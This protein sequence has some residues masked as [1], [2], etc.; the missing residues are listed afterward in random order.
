MNRSSTVCRSTRSARQSNT[1]VATAT[2]VHAVARALAAVDP[3]ARRRR[4]WATT[5]VMSASSFDR[6][7]AGDAVALVLDRHA[8][9]TRGGIAREQPVG[10]A[11][12]LRALFAERVPVI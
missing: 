12:E 9:R 11:R 5:A 4:K 1:T 8:H 7:V 3:I 6:L 10:V 2:I